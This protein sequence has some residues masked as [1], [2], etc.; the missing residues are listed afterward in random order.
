MQ[1]IIKKEIDE[2]VKKDGNFRK[3]YFKEKRASYPPNNER[4]QGSNFKYK[5]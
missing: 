5:I 4:L 1:I 2:I 3:K